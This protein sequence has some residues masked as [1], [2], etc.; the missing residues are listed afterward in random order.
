MAEYPRGREPFF[1]HK[2]VRRMGRVCA[3]LDMGADACWL[4]TVIA[5]L[6]DTKRYTEPVKWWN[7]QLKD[8]V[9]F[10]SWGKLD[11]ARKRAVEAGWLHYEPGG[12]GKVGKYWTMIPA[13]Y[14]DIPDGAF[15]ASDQPL[16]SPLAVK[17]TGGSGAILS[18]GGDGN[19]I[20]PG[21]IR[22]PS[23]D[24]SSLTLFPDPDPKAAVAA[25]TKKRKKAVFTPPTIEEVAAHVATRTVKIDPEEFW[26]HYEARGWKFKNGR[27]MTSWKSS[28]VTWEKNEK[29][30]A[31]SN[32]K[33]PEPAQATPTNYVKPRAK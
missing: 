17:E 31:F 15:D 7:D 27:T 25:A 2:L 16:S 19:V 32:N 23:G 13:A 8:I 10:R 30:G 20:Q 33:P 26:H 5:H 18:T 3:A 29:K 1:A 4:V 11:R 12:K 22:D 6:E 14:A 24:H 21:S 28:V 9:G